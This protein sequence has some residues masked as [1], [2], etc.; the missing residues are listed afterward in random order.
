M[1]A[2]V[3]NDETC[4]LQVKYFQ[5]PNDPDE[6]K[7]RISE[8]KTFGVD[9]GTNDGPAGGEDKDDGEDKDGGILLSVVIGDDR[10][11]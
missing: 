5:G 8:L 11:F 3:L 9:D 1:C 4:T 2:A 10:R 7:A 6:D